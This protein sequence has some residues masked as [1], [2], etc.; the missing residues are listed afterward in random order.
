MKD[1]FFYGKNNGWKIFNFPVPYLWILLYDRSDTPWNNIADE[2]DFLLSIWYNY[3][4][5]DN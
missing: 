4:D 3:P 5:F 1:L 2:R